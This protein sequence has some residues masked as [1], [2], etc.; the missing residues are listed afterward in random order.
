MLLKII[1]INKK[2]VFCFYPCKKF[3]FLHYLRF[4]FFDFFNLS[5][6]C[7]LLLKHPIFLIKMTA[8]LLLEQPELLFDTI[9]PY[10][11]LFYSISSMSC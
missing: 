6:T 8:E 10:K 5:I 11:N 2:E 7:M 1:P 3:C 9:T 4:L